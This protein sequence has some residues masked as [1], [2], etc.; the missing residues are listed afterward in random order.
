MAKTK[1]VTSAAAQATAIFNPKTRELDPFNG[2]F[3]NAK[4][5]LQLISGPT[6]QE[7]ELKCNAVNRIRYISATLNG[8]EFI[9]AT[10]AQLKALDEERKI[11]TEDN[12]VVIPFAD[13]SLRTKIGVSGCE[14]VTLPTDIIY[15]YVEF[16][17][18]QDND[19][20]NLSLSARAKVTD[21]KQVRYFLP[22]LVTET[23]D[24]PA[25]GQINHSYKQ[26]SAFR[27]VRRM[28]LSCDAN[29]ITR[30]EIHRDDKIEFQLNQDDNAFDLARLGKEVPD[31]F[32]PLDFLEYGF[33]ADGKLPTLNQKS[34]DF[35]I[36]KTSAG[37]VTVLQ[38]LVEVVALPN[39]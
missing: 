18:K 9:R 30:V 11:Y 12:R 35:K 31:G 13:F 33:G 25:G 5:S 1:T 3:Y 19:P 39:S 2:V 8:T 38:Q 17:E 34:L 26:G 37:P 23:W 10:P 24:H 20:A 6:Y 15:L 28:F 29:D 4:A 14:L 7:I 22:R 36:T 32:F 27:F 16:D 21:A